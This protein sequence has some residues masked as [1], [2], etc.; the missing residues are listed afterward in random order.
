MQVELQ[1]S[2]PRPIPDSRI[3]NTEYRIPNTDLFVIQE[4]PFDAA[5]GA[6]TFGLKDVTVRHLAT[7]DVQGDRGGIRA[8]IGE[9]VVLEGG[10]QAPGRSTDRVDA[11]LRLEHVAIVS[12]LEQIV[13]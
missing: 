6:I 4:L 13:L 5:V 8:L 1:P 3:P 11:C 12:S 2:D 10:N 9:R 7:I